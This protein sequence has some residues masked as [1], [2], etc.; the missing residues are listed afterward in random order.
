MISYCKISCRF[1]FLPRAGLPAEPKVV[2]RIFARLTMVKLT[3]FGLL[4]A[5]VLLPGFVSGAEIYSVQIGSFKQIE[6]AEKQC[7]SLQKKIDL[8]QKETWR[9]EKIGSRYAIRIGQFTQENPALEL[10]S[11]VKQTVPDAILLKGAS[12]KAKI[13]RLY[14]ATAP[15]QRKESPSGPSP[16]LSAVSSGPG[17]SRMETPVTILAPPPKSEPPP[18]GEKTIPGNKS[19]LTEKP[20][21][22]GRAM[23]WGTILEGSPLSGT[24][25]GMTSDKEIF[26]VKVRVTR[27]EQVKGSPNFLPDKEREVITLFSKARQPFFIPEQKIKALVEYKGDKYKRFF[28]IEQVEPFNP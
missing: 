4:T 10:L 14:E 16:S 15:R 23:L 2:F 9:I 22:I 1:R 8:S 3:F 18:P 19:T 11:R 24:S 20:L 27:T 21:E 5:L 28:W 6:N 12:K 26:R 7:R 13:V 17:E 25:L